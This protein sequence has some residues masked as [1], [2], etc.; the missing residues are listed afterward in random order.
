MLQDLTP[1][2][3]DFN[4]H[5]YL[6]VLNLKAERFEVMDSL[7]SK[8]NPGLLKDARNIVGSIKGLWSSNYSESKINIE[9]WP[10]KYIDTP[11][12]KTS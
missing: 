2:I 8:M 1:D 5:Y 6:I 3:E 11:K 4:G 7:R 12:Q 10:T 9:K